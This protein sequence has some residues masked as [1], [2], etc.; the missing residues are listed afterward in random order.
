MLTSHLTKPKPAVENH[1]SKPDLGP[2]PAEDQAALF[3]RQDLFLRLISNFHR[4][5]A[6]AAPKDTQK[7]LAERNLLVKQLNQK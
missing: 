4:Q 2:V 3:G 5:L 1:A 7:L 6:F